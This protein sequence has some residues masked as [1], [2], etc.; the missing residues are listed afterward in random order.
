MS[1]IELDGVVNFRDFGGGLGAGG[2]R[3]RT[4]RL[5]RSGHHATATEADLSALEALDF[6]LFV[7]LRRT[8]ERLRAPALRPASHRAHVIEHQGPSD[9][10]TAPHLV[11][12]GDADA[13]VDRVNQQMTVGYRY[14]PYD[15]F[16]VAIWREYFSRLAELDGP[17]LIN[18]HAGKDRTGFI[19]ALTLHVLGAPWDDIVEDYL[20]TNRFNRAEL[21]IAEIAAQFQE[22]HGR[23]PPDDLPRAMVSVNPAWLDAAF[24]S[25]A[26]Q[27]GDTETYLREVVG[28]TRERQEA[29]RSR[30]LV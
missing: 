19:C 3:I 28:L 23:A 16:Y 14:Y 13:T 22:A 10:A 9:Q 6:A 27:H 7:D 18:C 1:A 2:R 8:P 25:I 5:Y 29:I 11:S 12:L 20:A 24:A 30:L 17:V 4:G 26:E 21:R 15:P